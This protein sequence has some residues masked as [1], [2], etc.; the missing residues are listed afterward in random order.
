MRRIFVGDIQGCLE[1]LDR[2]L[3]EVQFGGSDVLYCAGDLV[4]RG[5]D[6]AGVLRRIRSLD[7]R[8]VLGNHDLKLLR[9]AHGVTKQSRSD[10]LSQVLDAPDAAD[11]LA[12]LEEQPVLRVEEDIVMVHGGIA[13]NWDNL[14]SVASAIN[15]AVPRF[16]RGG[17]DERIVFA[18]QVRYCDAEG[19]RPD[20]DYPPPGPPFRPWDEFYDGDRT[21]VF[22]HWARRG[23]VV[24]PRVRGLDTGALYGGQLTAWIA[25]EDYLVQVSGWAE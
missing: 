23:L 12:W 10:T 21:V 4:N 5:P 8:V 15:S 1:A 18:T 7:S 17:K 20:E 6:S 25:E 19:S 2:L 11:L 24:G 22:A 16:I 9:V 14:E 13:P 3:E